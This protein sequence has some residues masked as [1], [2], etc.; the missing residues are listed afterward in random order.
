MLGFFYAEVKLITKVKCYWIEA[1]PVLAPVPAPAVVAAVVAAF[2]ADETFFN[3]FHQN[4]GSMTF[5]SSLASNGCCIQSSDNFGFK[6]K[7][8]REESTAHHESLAEVGLVIEQYEKSSAFRRRKLSF[9]P[10]LSAFYNNGS[11]S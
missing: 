3:V 10:S 4:L 8:G 11:T 6:R 5:V 1:I 2:F 7:A 9:T